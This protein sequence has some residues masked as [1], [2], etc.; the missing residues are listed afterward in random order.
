M[1]AYEPTLM[2]NVPTGI[3]AMEV[4]HPFPVPIS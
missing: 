2:A 3:P 4:C 1:S